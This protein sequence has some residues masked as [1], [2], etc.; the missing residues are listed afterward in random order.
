MP[1]AA[2]KGITGISLAEMPFSL[3]SSDL[4]FGGFDLA[5]VRELIIW[6]RLFDRNPS[7]EACLGAGHPAPFG[8]TILFLS[9]Q[10]K[11]SV[12]TL[13]AMTAPSAWS[14][15]IIA[16][17]NGPLRDLIQV[18]RP[19]RSFGTLVVSGIADPLMVGLPTEEALQTFLDAI[20][21]R[22]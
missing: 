14:T 19:D 5:A 9:G 12:P 8:W 6:R 16:D 20:A 3:G 4:V 10:D 7:L 2:I 17:D 11:V 18:D 15:T 13:K 1:P 21:Q 22:S